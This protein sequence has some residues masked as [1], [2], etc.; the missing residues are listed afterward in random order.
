MDKQAK[1]EEAIISVGISFMGGFSSMVQSKI[2]EMLQQIKDAK[3]KFDEI[4]LQNN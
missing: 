1:L 4:E 3:A 2:G